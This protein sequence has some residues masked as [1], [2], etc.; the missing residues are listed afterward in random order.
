MSTNALK[1]L[2]ENFGNLTFG[3]M[4]YSLRS[5]DE[6]TQV[7]LAEELKVSKGL[8]CDIEKGRRLPTIE[9]AKEM[10]EFLGYPIEGFISILIQDQLRKA[11]LSMKVSIE[12]AS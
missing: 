7:Q 10:A 8:I 9:Q 11:N 4:L 1:F 12:K 5:T 6:V 2:R 3:E